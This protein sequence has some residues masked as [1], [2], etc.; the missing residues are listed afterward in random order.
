MLQHRPDSRELLTLKGQN[1]F[2]VTAKSGNIKA[3]GSMLKMPELGKL[4]NEKDRDGNTPLHIA[5]IWGHPRIV[6]ALSLDKRPQSR[7]S[8]PENSIYTSPTGVQSRSPSSGTATKLQRA[9]FEEDVLADSEVELENVLVGIVSSTHVLGLQAPPSPVLQQ[10]LKEDSDDSE[11]ELL[12]VLEG[13][14]SSVINDSSNPQMVTTPPTSNAHNP[15]L[16]FVVG[17]GSD[18]AWSQESNVQQSTY[19]LPCG[20]QIQKEARRLTCMALRVAG[21]PQSPHAKVSKTRKTS[22]AGQNSETEDCKDKVNAVLVVAALVVAATFTASFNVPGGYNN[23]NPDQ[24][25]AAMLAKLKFQEFMVCDTVAMYSSI[26]VIVTLL[27]ALLV[28]LC[29]MKDALKLAL[30]LLG[31]SIAM[32][33]IAFMAGVYLVVS[34]LTWLGK[35]ILVMGSNVVIVLAALF[36]PLCLSSSSNRWVF[37][38]LSYFP[39]RLLLYAFGC[40]TDRDEKEDE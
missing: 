20:V 17:Y 35:V 25:M 38:Q 2:H 21:G 12:E 3:V 16:G 23:S 34:T 31:I 36:I 32:M 27:W 7:P 4:L 18:I 11:A 40:Y 10:V 26:I 14:V 39:F 30:P 22:R 28:D 24:G 5:T 19:M 6:D 1:I 33:S 9:I 37:R 29:S 13:V 8:L 15:N